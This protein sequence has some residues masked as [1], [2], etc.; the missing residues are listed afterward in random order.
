MPIIQ[1]IATCTCFLK[2]TKFVEVYGIPEKPRQ[3]SA[4]LQPPDAHH[5]I[6]HAQRNEHALVLVGV[7]LRAPRRVRKCATLRAATSPCAIATGATCGAPGAV[8]RRRR[9][10]NRRS[11]TLRDALRAAAPNSR[12]LAPRGR[13]APADFPPADSPALPPPTRWSR[14][15]SS[16]LPLI[17]TKSSPQRV[18]FAEVRT[19]M[20]RRLQPPQSVRLQPLRNPAQD[21][22][23]RF[24]HE[25]SYRPR[26]GCRGTRRAHSR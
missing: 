17:S 25:Q 11:Q 22:R 3:I 19:S 24:Q 13:A 18:T 7:R 1:S 5:R 16:S 2:P 14:S 20:P 21:F 12:P 23:R 26:R 15:E 10:G 6:V 4:E 8:T 9:R